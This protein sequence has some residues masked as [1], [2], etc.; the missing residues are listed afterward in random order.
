MGVSES[1]TQLIFFIAA[2][3]V[4]STVVAVGTKMV[5]DLSAGINNRSE[6]MKDQMSTD[7]EIINDP[8]MVPN[9]PLLIYVKNVG[10]TTL[11]HELVTVSVD[12]VPVSNYTLSLTGNRTAFWEPTSVLTISVP[13][14]LAAGDHTVTVTTENGVS[15]Q[16]SFRT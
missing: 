14:H 10:R 4:A 9:D 1:S 3:V 11:N 8:T 2:M 15:D 16:F 13:V 12:G 7:I 6:E 5:Y